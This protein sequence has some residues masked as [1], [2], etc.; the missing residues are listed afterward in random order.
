MLRNFLSIGALQVAAM[1]VLMVRT[2][3][4]A[5]ILGPERVGAL[6]VVDRLLAVVAQT[7]AFSLPF[8]AVRFLPAAREAGEAA[9]GRLYR[10]MRDLLL[11]LTGI[12]TLGVAATY[13]LFPSAWREDLGA[14]RDVL[15]WAFLALP[16]TTLVPF[17]QNAVAGGLRHNRA[18]AFNAV[19]AVVFAATAIV[20]AHAAGLEGLYGAY[21]VGG[22]ALCVA[23]FARLRPRGAADD[24]RGFTAPPP[25][26]LR[27]SAVLLLLAFASP[28]AAWRVG[29][30]VFT[31][32]GDRATGFMQ[33][34]VGVSL[35][36]R[37]VLGAAHMVLLTPQVNRG[38]DL[39]ERLRFADAY[40][41][42]LSLLTAVCVPPLLLFPEV[43]VSILYSDRFLPGAAFVAAFTLTEIV[44]L[45]AGSYQAVIV[46]AGRLRYHVGQNVAAQTL[47]I[48][49]AA[50]LIPRYGVAGAA[51]ASLVPPCALWVGTTLY[52]RR[53]LGL[54]PSA[55]NLR[56][57]V[58]VI[59]VLAASGAAGLLLP[60]ASLGALGIK[61]AVGACL[62]AA[63][64]PATTREE[65]ARA[66]AL[67]RG[68][69]ARVWF[70]PPG[71][72]Q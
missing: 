65:R 10:S 12:A 40:Q 59:L 11:L 70:R 67:V 37:G 62:C 55:A 24:G 56:L 14:Y 28:Y 68:V 57:H 71:G 58:A 69:A 19:H 31:T 8:A 41:R 17:L 5:A 42:T 29:N 15:P 23:A 66:V 46:A 45:V 35:A 20:G 52:L 47:M 48:G 4:L 54:R 9:F 33:A 49:A 63:L 7:A 39:A 43:V 21:A 72:R 30:G 16:A 22:G 34:A 50:L 1:L 61:A 2:R 13:L 3:W 51:A 32:C 53:R 26:V 64:I 38:G 25:E 18:M 36:V 27:F 6:A 44:G 60:G